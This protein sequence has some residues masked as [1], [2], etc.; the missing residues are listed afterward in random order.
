MRVDYLRQTN[1]GMTFDV[2]SEKSPINLAYTSLS[3]PLHTDLP[4][5]ELPPGYQ[6]LH[7]FE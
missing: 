5:Q 1:F 3:L 7:F 4:N 6:F 2:I